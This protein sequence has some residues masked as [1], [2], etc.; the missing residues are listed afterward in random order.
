MSCDGLF[1]A[2]VAVP[3]VGCEELSLFKLPNRLVPDC[4]VEVAGAPNIEGAEVAEGV[5]TGVVDVFSAGL[6]KLKPAPP[7]GFAPPPPNRP[8]PPLSA[9]FA[10]PK[11]KPELP[12]VVLP[13]PPK[14][15]FCSPPDDAVLPKRLGAED[16]GASPVLC[17][18][19]GFAAP[20]EPKRPLEEVPDE[21]G[22]PKV[23][24]G[25]SD[26]VTAGD[27]KGSR[28]VNE[29]APCLAQWRTKTSSKRRLKSSECYLLLCVG[30]KGGVNIVEAKCDVKVG[31]EIVY[32]ALLELQSL[33]WSGRNLWPVLGAAVLPLGGMLRSTSTFT[34]SLI[35]S[36]LLLSCINYFRSAAEGVHRCQSSIL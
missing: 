11:L 20:A 14:S 31:Q 10:P 13:P 27:C 6:P 16:L 35:A 17:P 29:G 32:D 21:A 36:S 2:G 28:W 12:S 26:I 4:A 5:C 30:C 33:G 7:A 19:S 8:P 9:G 18:N 34:S 24:L 25:G 1:A 15:D 23:N 3:L 22:P